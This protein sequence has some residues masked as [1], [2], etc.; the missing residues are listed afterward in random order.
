MTIP[1]Y[2]PAQR[3]FVHL[4]IDWDCVEYRL[5]R[6]PAIGR[7]FP[8]TVLKKYEEK[9][10]YYCHYMAWRLGTWCDESSLQRLEELLCCAE[11]LDHW[12]REKESLVKSTDF[13]TFWSLVW[14][15][16]V[17]EY[18]C[19]IGT[20]VSWTKSGP[21]LTAAVGGERWFVECYTYHKSFGLFLFLEELLLKIDKSIRTSYDLWRQFSLPKEEPDQTPFLDTI[22]SPFLEP[23]YLTTKKEEAK[24]RY[25]VLLYEDP[26]SSSSLRVSVEGDASGEYF[27][28]DKK[29]GNEEAYLEVALREAVKAKQGKNRLA[30]HHPNLV[31]TNYA[32]SVDYQLAK[33]SSSSFLDSGPNI[34]VLTV[35]AVGI[36]ERL[37]RKKLAVKGI[38][39]SR[40]VNRVSLNRIVE[41][42]G[43]R[44]YYSPTCAPR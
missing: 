4:L 11:A 19:G 10:P 13:G 25:P 16:Q 17:A 32:L 43:S 36:D 14:Q 42:S 41:I 8:L 24:R 5:K 6:Y 27:P 40:Q 39:N 3:H 26:N 23:S 22:L 12:D 44:K 15:L 29:L 1:H 38:N 2:G 21:D 9:K 30:E 33:S 37:T 31:A 7:T 34:D 18:L 35:S 28:L 20:E